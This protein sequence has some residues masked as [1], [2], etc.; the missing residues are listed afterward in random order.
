MKKHWMKKVALALVGIPAFAALLGFV[1]MSLWNWLM[2]AL[3]GLTAITFWQA[4]GLLILSK[5]LFGGWKGGH[6][7]EHRGAHWKRRFRDKWTNMSEEEREKYR[8]CWG[9]EK[10]T[11]VGEEGK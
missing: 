9:R 10:P 5:I 4:L 2:P 8:R 1:V 7:R 11:T 3:F 6:H